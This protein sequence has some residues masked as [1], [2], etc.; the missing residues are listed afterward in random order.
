MYLEATP[1]LDYALRVNTKLIAASK[2]L[3]Y[4]FDEFERVVHQEQ[5][6]NALFEVIQHRI[7]PYCG[8]HLHGQSCNACQS[9]QR[10][11]NM[12]SSVIY[13]GNR[14]EDDWQ[15]AVEIPV[16]SNMLWIEGDSDD[17]VDPLAH[18]VSGQ[19]L[20]DDLLNQLQ[21]L[22]A[23]GDGEIAE[24]LIGSLNER[25]YLEISVQEISEQLTVDIARVEHVLAQLQYLE[26]CGIGA[27][28][29]RECLL[30]QLDAAD[31]RSIIPPLTRVLI[32]QH[33]DQLGSKHYGELARE[34]K[35]S[36]RDVEQARHYIRDN[37]HPFPAYLYN[38]NIPYTHLLDHVVYVRP[39][40]LIR[41]QGAI[42]EFELLEEKS[43]TFH[44]DP[45]LFASAG[46]RGPEKKKSEAERYIHHYQERAKFF[47]ECIHR[48]WSTMKRVMELIIDHQR[49]FLEKGPRYLSPLTRVQVAR[50]LGL[51]ESTISRTVTNKH[52]LLPNGRL[53]SLADFFDG[54]LGPKD[55]LQALV[56]AEQPGSRLND[57]E[58]A[59]LLTTH[60]VPLARRTVT[61]YRKQLGIASSRERTLI[62]SMHVQK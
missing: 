13:A 35:V 15:G 43:Y 41:A 62:A 11:S 36:E 50:Q 9:D 38:A 29:L 39:D 25:G 42:F 31:E 45:A 55:L 24:M 59:S 32:E 40:I 51:D 61:K 46:C 22:I 37:L 23:P 12:G 7:C 52:A 54:T 26:P 19:T 2:M 4:A 16:G 47:I 6:E 14:Q 60:G 53:M 17:S 1:R 8:T 27:R 57:E 49:P 18:I 28:T 34:L 5:E 56:T 33:L 3:Q 44:I 20:L 10:G 21:L 48:R 30:I 58:L